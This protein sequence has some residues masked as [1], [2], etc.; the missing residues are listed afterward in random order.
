MLNT[1]AC[2]VRVILVILICEVFVLMIFIFIYF[3]HAPSPSCLQQVEK[4]YAF[5]IPDVPEKSEYLE[6]R[7]AVSKNY[8]LL[9]ENDI[10]LFEI[11]TGFQLVLPGLLKPKVH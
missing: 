11:S 3:L 7:Y 6:V 5:E 1:G 4:N 8:W 10:S 9:V 2:I